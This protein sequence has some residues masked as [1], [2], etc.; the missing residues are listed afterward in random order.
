[1]V[2]TFHGH[3]NLRKVTSNNPIRRNKS[4]SEI[5]SVINNGLKGYTL[6]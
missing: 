1:M 2:L 5:K 6:L 3:S 4:T